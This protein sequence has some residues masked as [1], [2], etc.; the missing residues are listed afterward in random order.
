LQ[1]IKNRLISY[2][3]LTFVGLA[4]AIAIVITIGVSYV[5]TVGVQK[6]DVLRIVLKAACR[7]EREFPVATDGG[8]SSTAIGGHTMPWGCQA[9]SHLQ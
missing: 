9:A 8:A 3:R 1:E 7:R 6:R 4:K 5:R 2:Y